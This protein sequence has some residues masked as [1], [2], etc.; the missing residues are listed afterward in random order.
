MSASKRPGR[1]MVRDYPLYHT[2][3]R[4]E[5]DKKKT[6]YTVRS[7]RNSRG[8]HGGSGVTRKRSH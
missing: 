6:K 3:K 8:V 5:Q 2:S 1:R 4:A 7:Q